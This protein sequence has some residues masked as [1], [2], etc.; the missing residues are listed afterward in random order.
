[1]LIYQKIV[2]ITKTTKMYVKSVHFLF[3]TE[4]DVYKLPYFIKSISFP[5]ALLAIQF[6]MKQ[7]YL[8]LPSS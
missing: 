1:M 7:L 3:L 4:V 6:P 5:L 8:H 2:K